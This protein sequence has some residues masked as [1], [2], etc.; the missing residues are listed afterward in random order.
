MTTDLSQLPA[1]VTFTNLDSYYVSIDLIPFGKV[2]LNPGDS[3]IMKA[4]SSEEIQHYMAMNNEYL[5]VIEEPVVITHLKP[6]RKRSKAATPEVVNEGEKP[7]ETLAKTEE[8]EADP[9]TDDAPE[10]KT[11]EKSEESK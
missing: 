3:L 5:K 4:T 6:P 2:V 1:K 10:D 7:A 11:D 8:A 9:I